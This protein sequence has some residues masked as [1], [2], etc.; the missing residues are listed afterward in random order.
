MDQ[1]VATAAANPAVSVVSMSWGEDE[2]DGEQSE[3]P[4]NLTPTGRT[5]GVTFLAAT[6]DWDSPAIYPAILAG[7]RGGRRRPSRF[8]RTALT[9]PNPSGITTT[10][11]VPAAA[12]A[13]RNRSRP[14]RTA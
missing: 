1:A 2:F 5:G 12:S 13:K 7:R 11:T 9:S 10:V 8:N 3:D 4:F 14:I 6:G